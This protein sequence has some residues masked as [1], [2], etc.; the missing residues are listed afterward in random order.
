MQTQYK[1]APVRQRKVLDLMILATAGVLA[2]KCVAVGIRA[3]RCECR[4]VQ[5]EPQKKS[6]CSVCGA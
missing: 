4:C 6:K 3:I 2:F 1:N 5:S